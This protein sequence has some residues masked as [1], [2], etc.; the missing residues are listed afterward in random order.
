[1]DNPT[2]FFA[3]INPMRK[4]RI[5]LSHRNSYHYHCSQPIEMDSPLVWFLWHVSQ[6]NVRIVRKINVEVG[7]EDSLFAHIA[8]I[9]LADC[10]VS[11]N[12][13]LDD[14][15]LEEPQGNEIWTSINM[16]GET[17]MLETSPPILGVSWSNLTTLYIFK[18][19]GEKPPTRFFLLVPVNG[20]TARCV[21]LTFVGGGG[22]YPS[23]TV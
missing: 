6:P 18:W 22:R 23:T 16:S 20:G 12:Q 10:R 9:R 21:V 11:I 7:P 1:M 15:R 4:K 17:S 5:I 19:V 2:D 14:C 8:Q 3:T 13:P